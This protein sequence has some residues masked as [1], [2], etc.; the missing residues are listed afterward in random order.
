[1]RRI[2]FIGLILYTIIMLRYAFPE[3]ITLEHIKTIH[4]ALFIL[5]IFVVDCCISLWL[6]QRRK[7]QPPGNKR[8][9]ERKKRKVSFW[10]TTYL[11]SSSIIAAFLSDNIPLERIDVKLGAFIFAYYFFFHFIPYMKETH[12][13]EEDPAELEKRELEHKR[14]EEEIEQL[15]KQKWYLKS[16]IVYAL[17]FITPPIGYIYVL[18]LRKK[19]PEDIKMTYL[20]VATI[21]T[22]L[23]SLKFLPP[24]L[25]AI[26]I[27]GV[28]FLVFIGKY[29][30]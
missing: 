12:G 27:V 13:G 11:F 10:I 22:G 24:Y 9:I 30:K 2:Y 21:M 7:E 4:I 26:V 1:M 14:I 8:E 6:D 19:M 16:K 3:K 18:L 17:C 5:A 29:V 23:W 28:A 15:G 25:Y 20:V